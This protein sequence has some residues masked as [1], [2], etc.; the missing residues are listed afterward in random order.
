MATDFDQTP[1]ASRLAAHAGSLPADWKWAALFV[2]PAGF[3]REWRSWLAQAQMAEERDTL[4]YWARRD[5]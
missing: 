2:P 3:E 4:V 1:S 5:R